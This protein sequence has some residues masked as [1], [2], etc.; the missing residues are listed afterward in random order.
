MEYGSNLQLNQS[1]VKRYK[2][3]IHEFFISAFVDKKLQDKALEIHLLVD[4]FCI[5]DNGIWV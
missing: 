4:V 2:P 5:L 3:R 1:F